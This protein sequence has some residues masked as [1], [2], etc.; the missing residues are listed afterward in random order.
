V[1]PFAVDLV[2]LLEASGVFPGASGVELDEIAAAGCEVEIDAGR[3][4]ALPQIRMDD[5]LVVLEGTAAR[6][7]GGVS[8]EL[9]RGAV[10]G[11]ELLV[12]A[13]S[14]ATVEATTAMR[15]ASIPLT[16][17]RELGWGAV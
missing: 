6:T 14:S 9:G 13:T 15:L 2:G 7:V 12:G 5:V 8:A 1:N 10:I 4:L 16:R 17:L 11:E 3:V